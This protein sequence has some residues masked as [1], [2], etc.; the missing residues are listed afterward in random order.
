MRYSLTIL[1]AILLLASC[2]KIDPDANPSRE[3]TMRDG[4]WK[5]QSGTVRYKFFD[6]LRGRVDSSANM[7]I[8][9]CRNDD[10]LIFR[11]K[12]EG[13][14]I[15]GE[16]TCSINE[17]AEVEFRWGLSRNDSSIFI[18]DAKEYF[19]S[20]IN[21]E[22]IEF[23]NDKF[24]IRYSEYIDVLTKTDTATGTPN[25]YVRDT[26][27]TTMYFTKIGGGEAAQ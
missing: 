3:E 8:K 9:E 20:D 14:H 5:M 10:E 2:T 26:V 19:G 16:V 11:E 4:R 18:Y 25:E 7:E 22:F 13:A 24:G 17:T 12:N 23:Y 21:A 6:I 1:S 15:P 27:I